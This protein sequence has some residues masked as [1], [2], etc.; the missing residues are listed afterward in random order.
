MNTFRFNIYRT[1][2][3][4]PGTAIGRHWIATFLVLSAIIAMQ[5]AQAQDLDRE[6]PR[7]NNA[8]SGPGNIPTA[9]PASSANKSAVPSTGT[10]NFVDA[11]I[12]SV[13]AAVGDYTNTTFII[14][15]RVKGTLTL[16]SEKPLTKAQA[17]Q[18]LTSVLRMRGYTVVAGNGY[19]KVVPEADAKLQAGPIQA[20]RPDLGI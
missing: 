18:M 15:P 6:E 1:L 4:I 10:L 20:A 19:I 5:A 9:Q 13:I 12:E 17:F 16:V 11:D 3:Q 7:A 2:A 8:I 14:D